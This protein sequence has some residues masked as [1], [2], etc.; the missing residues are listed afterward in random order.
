M[1]ASIDRVLIVVCPRNYSKFV[2]RKKSIIKILSIW[3]FVLLVMIQYHFSYVFSPSLRFCEFRSVGKSWHSQVWP[4]IRLIIFGFLPCSITCSCS[5]II[6][7]NRFYRRPSTTSE[8]SGSRQMRT[9]SLLLVIYSIYYTLTVLPL[10]I[11]LFFHRYFLA[12]SEI[13]G[14][15][16]L[17]CSK[18][19]QWKTLTK[20]CTL[21]MVINYS[22][23]FFVHYIISLKFRQDVRKLISRCCCYCRMFHKRTT[24]LRAESYR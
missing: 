23:K 13:N 8:T 1:M 18:Y 17:N 12:D 21:L 22:N 15:S 6:F 19:S 24:N 16:S 3:I 11:L 4:S 9:A 2:N 5:I 7:Q 14:K 20:F 10:N